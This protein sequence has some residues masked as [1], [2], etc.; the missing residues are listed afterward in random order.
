MQVMRVSEDKYTS[1][2][3]KKSTAQK[4]SQIGRKGES[5]D[6]LI[7][8]LLENSKKRKASFKV[9]KEEQPVTN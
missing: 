9:K 7:M 1:I 5:Y 4:L 3:V 2:R 8:W 6:N